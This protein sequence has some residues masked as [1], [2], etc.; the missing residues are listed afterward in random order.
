MATIISSSEFD[1]K[2]LKADKPV[3]VDFFATWCGPCKRLGPV[4]DEIAESSSS[5]YVYKIDVDD[6]GDI[7]EKYNVMSV[8]TMVVFKNGEQTGKLVGLHTKEEIINT[9]E[10]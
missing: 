2:V 10:K 5:F 7:A 1:E 3:L 9:I 4:L 8:P 6:S